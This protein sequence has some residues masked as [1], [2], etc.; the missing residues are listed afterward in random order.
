MS[1]GTRT[2]IIALVVLLLGAVGGGGFFIYKMMSKPVVMLSPEEQFKKD[3]ETAEY[4]TLKEI[5][6]ELDDQTPWVKLTVSLAV[7]AGSTEELKKKEP[8][9]SR[10]VLFVVRSA[11]AKQ[12]E[13][14][15]G[16]AWLENAL[17]EA[18][19]KEDPALKAN[20]IKAL[21]TQL[22]LQQ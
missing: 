2:L 19:K 20:V 3:M 4:I 9:I 1:R 7:K 16:Q 11:K 12:I 13:G 5:V 18:L 6:T 17:T 10:T 15:A 8:L 22:A 21:V 14:A